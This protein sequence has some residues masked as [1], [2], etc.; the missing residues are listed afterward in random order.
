MILRYKAATVSL[1]LSRLLASFLSRQWFL[2]PAKVFLDRAKIHPSSTGCAKTH[3]TCVWVQVTM[4]WQSFSASVANPTLTLLRCCTINSDSKLPFFL[5][6][7]DLILFAQHETRILRGKL[8][9]GWL[10]SSTR[11]DP[12]MTSVPIKTTWIVLVKHQ[13]YSQCF[14]QLISYKTFYSCFAE[15]DN[16]TLILT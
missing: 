6:Q 12:L 7:F 14:K 1:F 16:R 8:T 3:Q 4:S 10:W 13:D 2:R 15:C 9:T 11:S 5:L